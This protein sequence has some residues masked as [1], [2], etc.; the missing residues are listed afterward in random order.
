MN[1]H[2]A[3]RRAVDGDMMFELFSDKWTLLVLR[4]IYL[5][6]G[7]ARFNAL[8][9]QIAGISQKTLTQSLRRLERNGLVSR[10]LVDTA[11]PGVEYSLT[12]LGNSLKLPLS[13]LRDW[14]ESNAHAIHH[15][16]QIFDQKQ[17]KSPRSMVA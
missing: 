2:A 12:A 10:H 11:P 7:A 16:Q 1:D 13:V 9:R 14:S 8:K 3:D 5:D 4:R 6:G 17:T 15:A